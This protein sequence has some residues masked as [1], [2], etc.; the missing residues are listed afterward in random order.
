M[1][2]LV[3][4]IGFFCIFFS[5]FQQFLYFQDFNTNPGEYWYPLVLLGFV[6]GGVGVIKYKNWARI[7]IISL[8]IYL[9]AFS[10]I[11]AGLFFL[12]V[13]PWLLKESIK[14]VI[15]TLMNL[16]VTIVLLFFLLSKETAKTF[17]QIKK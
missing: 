7:L 16:I 15:P 8:S 5:I 11:G 6:I 1:K 10:L 12:F 9:F 2:N 4:F 3:K 17:Q 14:E 13:E